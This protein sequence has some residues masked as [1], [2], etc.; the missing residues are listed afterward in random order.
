MSRNKKLAIVG[1]LVVTVMV[2]SAAAYAVGAGIR[3][4]AV[5]NVKAKTQTDKFLTNSTDWIDVPNARFRMTVKAGAENAFIGQFSAE[6][7]CNGADGGNDW[8]SVRILVDDAE[9][10]PA[11]GGDFAFDSDEPGAGLWEAHSMTRVI[12]PLTEGKYNFKVQA[13][14]TTSNVIFTLDDWTFVVWKAK[15]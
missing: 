14:V 10:S 3:A 15:G 6:S 13:K 7:L 2:A 8:C 9:M 11:A 4:G 5:E 12:G 1:A